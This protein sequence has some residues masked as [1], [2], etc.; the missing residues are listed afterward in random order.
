MG[1]PALMMPPPP[2]ITPAYED[3]DA[4]LMVSRWPAPRTSEPPVP[5]RFSIVW[6][7]LFNVSVPLLML[8]SQIASHRVEPT[9]A[10]MPPAL[11]VIEPL[12]SLVPWKVMTP[13]AA[14]DQ[15]AIPGRDG[16]RARVGEV[17]EA[18]AERSAR[19][20]VDRQSA[21][22]RADVSVAGQRGNLLAQPVE[23]QD[24][25]AGDGDVG[26]GGKFVCCWFESG[27]RRP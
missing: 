16:A 6:A 20:T 4:G 11:R 7:A 21:R 10:M 25:G 12:M 24:T 15:P 14:L 3:V 27:A 9:S 8:M 19:R 22:A 13:V 18:S 26:G 17:L 2:E 5:L 23:V 1:E